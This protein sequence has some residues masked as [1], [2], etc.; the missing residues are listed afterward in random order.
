LLWE[1]VRSIEPLD[2]QETYDICVPETG[3][4][5]AEGI[6]VHN[7]GAIEAEADIVAFIYRPAYY[8]RKEAVSEAMDEK[9]DEER[10]PGEY[11]GEEA[12][13]IIAKQRNG[14]TGTVKLSF[15]PKYARFD[16]LAEYREESPF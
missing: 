11:D 7:S 8:E 5:I 13:V 9:A 4:F 2:E 14:P 3:N 10:R 15:L 12:E 1:R 16:N 6:V